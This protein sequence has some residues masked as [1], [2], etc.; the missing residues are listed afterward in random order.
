MIEERARVVAT[1]EG[2]AWVETWRKGACGSCSASAG[3]GTATLAKVLGQKRARVRALNGIGAKVGEDVVVGI[4]DGTLM[5]GSFA[6]Y[7]VPVLVMLAAA[8]LGAALA[9]DEASLKEILSTLFGLSGLA[10][11]LL[12]LRR[13]AGRIGSDAA[14]QPVI[15]RRAGCAPVNWTTDG[16]ANKG[17]ET[18]SGG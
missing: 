6:V 10:V 18:E 16:F 11:G 3:C 17:T 9:G 7:A 1:E 8:W 12:W 15:L 2:I 14:W 13:F 4:P 5:K